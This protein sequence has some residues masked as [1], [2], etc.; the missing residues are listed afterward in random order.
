LFI[1]DLRNYFSIKSFFTFGAN[2]VFEIK[3]ADHFGL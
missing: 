3:K 2:Q 1:N